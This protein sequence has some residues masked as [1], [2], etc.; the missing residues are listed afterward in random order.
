MAL[1]EAF[2]SL[3]EDE[4]VRFYTNGSNEYFVENKRTPGVTLRIGGFDS[5]G[6]VITA[7][8]CHLT[9][10]GVNGL[11]ALVVSS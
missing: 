4:N 1:E 10:W 6:L 7:Q 8:G 3:Y 11:P 2:P 9:P 5:T